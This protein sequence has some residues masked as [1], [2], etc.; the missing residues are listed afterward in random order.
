MNPWAVAAE[1]GSAVVKK[2]A[3]KGAVRREAGR[4]DAVLGLE[5]IR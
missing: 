4:Q 5:T 1:G 2:L 3:L